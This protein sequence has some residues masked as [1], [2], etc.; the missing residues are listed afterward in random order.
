LKSSLAH[1][2]TIIAVWS[3]VNVLVSVQ[4][5]LP[6]T[7][8]TGLRLTALHVTTCHQPVQEGG[9]KAGHSGAAAGPDY[10]KRTSIRPTCAVTSSRNHRRIW[11]SLKRTLPT[12]R[13][14]MTA[15]SRVPRFPAALRDGNA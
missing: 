11:K 8:D 15:E 2:R 9:I 4:N 5:V 10:K 3:W 14:A 6:L 7:C 12:I 1:C 13:F